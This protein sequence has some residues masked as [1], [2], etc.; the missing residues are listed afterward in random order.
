M[1]SS[2][3]HVC[4]TCINWL[5]WAPTSIFH[6]VDCCIVPFTTY[7]MLTTCIMIFVGW[8]RSKGGYWTTRSQRPA[9]T[10]TAYPLQELVLKSYKLTFPAPSARK[11]VQASHE[12]FQLVEKVAQ[13]FLQPIIKRSKM[14][15][16]THLWGIS[17]CFQCKVTNFPM[18]SNFVFRLS[19]YYLQS[20]P[21]YI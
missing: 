1:L 3:C 11:L 14:A 19:P 8:T 13:F 16:K 20:K 17:L 10:S 7:V 6:R 21:L 12:W 4:T 15:Y 9:G 18:M 5:K 2:H